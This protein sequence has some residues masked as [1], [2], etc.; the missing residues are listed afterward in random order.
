MK[1][2]INPQETLLVHGMVLF[3][4][5]LFMLRISLI[6]EKWWFWLVLF[7]NFLLLLLIISAS[8]SVSASPVRGF[9]LLKSLVGAT[10][11]WSKARKSYGGAG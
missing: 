2:S 11:D 4:S 6:S 7:C 5:T 10:T 1:S 9:S 8:L 3:E